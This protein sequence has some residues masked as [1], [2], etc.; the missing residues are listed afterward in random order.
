MASAA[1]LRSLLALPDFRRYYLGQSLSSFGDSLT[2][3]AL[4]FAVLEITGSPAALGIV[5]LSSRLPVI[6]L[7]LLGGAIGDRVSRRRIMLFTDVVRCAVQTTTA[8]LLVTGTAE[9]WMLIAL[10]LIAGGGSAFFNPAAQG[11]ITSVVPKDRLAEANSAISVTKSTGQ[12]VALAASGTMVA[13]IGTGYSLLVDALTFAGSALLL[14]RLPKELA[15]E[16]LARRTGVL[17]SIGEGLAVV[18]E[19]T[20]LWAWIVHVSLGNL[21]VICPVMVLGPFIADEHLGGAPAWAAIGICYAVGGLA[22]GVVAGR[23]KPSRP[24]VAAMVSF[25]AIVPFPALLALPGWVPFVAAAG[26]AAGLQQAVYVVLQTTALQQNVPAEVIARSS[27]VSM[28]GGLVAAPVGMALAG[29]AAAAFGARAVLVTGAVAAVVLSA[30][31][32]LLPAVRQLRADEPEGG[33]ESP[34]ATGADEP[35][36]GQTATGQTVTKRPDS[37]TEAG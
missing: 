10:Q 25:L 13:T 4:A 23:W 30:A 7:A 20:W 27:S 33:T 29:P 2:P 8:V 14:W 32:L 34:S 22:G 18:R 24:M 6:F 9:I 16:A 5:L 31:A 35:G 1:S 21:I 12:I 36:T 11:L 3:L 17:K 37:V 28:L 26:F 19:R 15:S